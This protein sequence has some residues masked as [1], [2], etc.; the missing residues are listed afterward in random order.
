MIGRSKVI[1]ALTATLRSSVAMYDFV[2]SNFIGFL[3]FFLGRY[4]IFNNYQ[5][6]IHVLYIEFY[7][8]I[9]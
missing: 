7:C 5:L 1:A 8:F 2:P 9:D 6:K 3:S 4:Y